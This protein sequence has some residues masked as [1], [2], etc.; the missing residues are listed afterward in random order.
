MP[1][2]ALYMSISLDGFIA[3]PNERVD[4]GL[5]DG[6]G[7]LHEWLPSAGE[8]RADRARAHFWTWQRLAQEGLTDDEAAQLMADLVA[9]AATPRRA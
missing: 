4:N 6:R 5:G 2:T 8:S 7:R 9:C 3:G 1:A